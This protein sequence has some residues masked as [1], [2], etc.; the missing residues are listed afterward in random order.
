L[1]TTYMFFGSQYNKLALGW[2]PN[3]QVALP[4]GLRK[5]S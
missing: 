1:H 2:P 3:L 5:V 4:K